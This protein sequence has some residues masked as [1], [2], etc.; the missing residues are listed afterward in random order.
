MRKEAERVAQEKTRR[1]QVRRFL[2]SDIGL[3]EFCAREGLN[4]TRFRADVIALRASVG[5]RAAA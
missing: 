5:R 2:R 3:P 1:A 4:P